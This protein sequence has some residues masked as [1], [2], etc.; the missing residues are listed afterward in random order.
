MRNC[1]PLRKT[2]L[3]YPKYGS[4]VFSHKSDFP[5]LFYSVLM[6]RNGHQIRSVP[7]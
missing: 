2:E 3:A 1:N 6:A 4:E 5:H 7:N